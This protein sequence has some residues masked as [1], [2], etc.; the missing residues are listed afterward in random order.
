M[1]GMKPNMARSMVGVL[2]TCPNAAVEEGRIVG[3]P[4]A[5]VEKFIGRVRVSR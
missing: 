5:R 2:R 4:A 1:A 3:N